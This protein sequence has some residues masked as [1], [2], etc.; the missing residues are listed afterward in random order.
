M[1]RAT[2]QRNERSSRGGQFLSS[3]RRASLGFTLVELLVVIAIIGVLVSMLLPAVQSARETARRMQ[4]RNNLRQLGL[5]LSLYEDRTGLLPRSG[6]DFEDTPDTAPPII[7]P[8]PPLRGGPSSGLSGGEALAGETQPRRD[9]SSLGWIV[10]MLPHL[11]QQPLFDRFSF[12]HLATEQPDALAATLLPSVLVCPSDAAEGKVYSHTVFTRN[13]EFAKGNYAA[14]VC[15]THLELQNSFYGA[16]GGVPR[17]GSEVED[18]RSN[19]LF[20]A[21]VRRRDEHRDHRGAW[22]LPY[23]GASLLAADAHSGVDFSDLPSGAS[24][25]VERWDGT[26][27]FDEKSRPYVLTPNH[28]HLNQ[29][30]VFHC[31]NPEDAELEGM[32]CTSEFANNRFGWSSAAPRSLHTGGVQCVY[33]DNHVGFLSD[34]ID[35]KVYALLIAAKDGEFADSSK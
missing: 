28:I 8:T 34:T 5:S 18:G 7:P 11:E 25:K 15:P 20:A 13:R 26:Y 1:Q 14:Y 6:F 17:P 21:E 2:S 16:L 31:I 33:L 12:K 19:T 22:A 27:V 29:D 32:P 35:P 23:S 4:C 30:V 24:G 3:S 10:S 9:E